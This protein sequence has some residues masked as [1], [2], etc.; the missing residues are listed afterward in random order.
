MTLGTSMATLHVVGIIALL[1]AK[2]LL[3]SPATLASAMMTIT[4]ILDC[5]GKPFLA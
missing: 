5:N 1:K 2:N 3:W 4:N